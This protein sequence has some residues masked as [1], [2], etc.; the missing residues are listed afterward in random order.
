MAARTNPHPTNYP[1]FP[2]NH[3]DPPSVLPCIKPSSGLVQEP[4]SKKPQGNAGFLDYL[5][6]EMIQMILLHFDIQS[7]THFESFNPH[8]KD[9]VQSLLEYRAIVKHASKALHQILA[10]ESGEYITLQT[11]YTKLCTAKCESCG[12]FASNLYLITCKRVCDSCFKS[13]TKWYPNP[14]SLAEDILGLS[15]AQIA[16]LPKFHSPQR[17]SRYQLRATTFQWYADREAAYDIAIKSGK[18]SPLSLKPPIF[19]SV[20]GIGMEY[21]VAP[22]C[23]TAGRRLPIRYDALIDVPWLNRKTNKGE[24]G[25]YCPRCNRTNGPS[26]LELRRLLTDYYENKD[27]GVAQVRVILRESEE[28]RILGLS[29]RWPQWR[30]Y[31]KMSLLDHLWEHDGLDRLSTEERKRNG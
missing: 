5:P 29:P 10:I 31:A 27:L 30:K 19:D 16:T 8:T 1:E 4:N 17:S 13:K 14:C 9:L 24:H 7:I 26:G 28:K 18:F 22:R 2:T 21:Y 23:R 11:L 20:Y 25:M 3:D 6:L 12:H 15:P